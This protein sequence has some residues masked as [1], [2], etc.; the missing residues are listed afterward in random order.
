MQVFGK[1]VFVSWKLRLKHFDLF[2]TK[3]QIVRHPAKIEFIS[4]SRA[5][6]IYD[7]DGARNPF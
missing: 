5:F 1:N 2:M 4:V 7:M 6:D 3:H